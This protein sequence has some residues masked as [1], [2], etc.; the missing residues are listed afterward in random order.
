M[1]H[2]EA[3]RTAPP[4]PPRGCRTESGAKI[5]KREGSPKRAQRTSKLRDRALE[6][7]LQHS[8]YTMRHGQDAEISVEP[9]SSV[10][11]QRFTYGLPLPERSP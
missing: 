5:K 7:W 9:V 1:G 4:A 8:D 3:P 10:E 6:E 11:E 2:G